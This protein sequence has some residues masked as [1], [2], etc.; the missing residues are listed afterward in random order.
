MTDAAVSSSIKIEKGKQRVY[1][2]GQAPAIGA[3]H[4]DAL[5]CNS[6]GRLLLDGRPRP[7]G[8]GHLHVPAGDDLQLRMRCRVQASRLPACMHACF[9][10]KSVLLCSNGPMQDRLC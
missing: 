9:V 8:A 10:L 2:A 7:Q 6:R 3:A 1:Q 4:A 5:V